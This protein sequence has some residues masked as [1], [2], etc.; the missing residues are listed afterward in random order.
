MSHIKTETETVIKKILPYLK[1]RGYD[2]IKDLDFESVATLTDSYSKGF[3]DIL[4][5]LGKK[6]AAFLIEAKRISKKLNNKDRDQAIAYAKTKEINVPFVVVTNGID[7]QCFNTK[8]KKRILWDG[9]MV[10]KI[11]NRQ[12]IF[13]VLRVLKANPQET[14]I[15]ISNDVSLPYRPGLPFRQLNALFYKGHST[16]RKIEKNE[17]SAFADFSKLLFLRLFRRKK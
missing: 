13:Q 2:I 11:P 15:G 1:R 10:D 6:N 5:T 7:I 4:V 8:N 3:V 16:I 14:Y 12:Q 17:E 9:K